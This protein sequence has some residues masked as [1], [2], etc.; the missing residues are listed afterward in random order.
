MENCK[1]LKKNL[2]AYMEKELPTETMQLLD[3]HVRDCSS[4]AAI[5]NEFAATMTII[6]T[7]KSIE[8]RPFAE[9]RILQGIH[10]KLEARRHASGRPATGLL[11]PVVV[12]LGMA[13]ALAIGYF[14]GNDAASAKAQNSRVKESVEA[15]RSD[16][17]VP[18]FLDDDVFYFTE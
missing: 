3:T 17:N 1:I 2:F 14:V 9:T 15:C 13:A 18:E 7:Q 11:K 8:P 4:C 12:S 16:L 6:E 10:S 5:V